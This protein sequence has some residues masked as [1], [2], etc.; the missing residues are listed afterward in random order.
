[1]KT[2]ICLLFLLPQLVWA[3]NEN[4][5]ITEKMKPLMFQVEKQLSTQ[6][7]T[8][9][10]ESLKLKDIAVRTSLRIDTSAVTK[11]YNLSPKKNKFNLPGLDESVSNSDENLKNYSP[12]IQ[13]V[14]LSIAEL[15]VKV[16]SL[17]VFTEMEKSD[18][19]KIIA[20]DL[21]TLKLNK[22]NYSFYKSKNLEPAPEPVV[23]KRVEV[24]DSK[25]DP[26]P[27][28]D[29][30][31]EENNDYSQ[32]LLA[33][34]TLVGVLL[35]VAVF[36]VGALLVRQFKNMASS[37]SSAISQIDV[38]PDHS[39]NQKSA[40]SEV[41]TQNAGGVENSVRIPQLFSQIAD[42]KH[43]FAAFMN[44][45]SGIRFY[46]I[47]EGISPSLREEFKKKLNRSQHQEYLSFLQAMA[48]GEVHPSKIAEASQQISRELS[49]YVHDADTFVGQLT[50]NKLKSLDS[51][52]LKN[53]INE[54]NEDDFMT[55][56]QVT[57]PVEMSLLLNE[58][59][60]ILERF[61]S[62][63]VREVRSD[64]LT[65]I[66]RKAEAS[67]D[68]PPDMGFSHELK[69]REF[70]PENVE[71]LLNQKLGKEKSMWEELDQ[72]GMESL[73][74]FTI[75]LS[76]KEA[77][78]FVSMIPEDIRADV[79][80]HLPD[81]KREQIK[82]QGFEVSRRSMELKHQFFQTLRA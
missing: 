35:V 63:E 44:S 57:D 81:L 75:G 9:L 30:L 58:N 78:L 65:S 76:P 46:V 67:N 80:R 68:M 56:A 15:N 38:T 69:L 41:I 20:D 10:E 53:L 37:L 36:V 43:F 12:T 59:P 31:P 74:D 47:S 77:A 5:V 29:F 45:F 28:K 32:W 7:K 52:S 18:I 34:L 51:V 61:E 22:I 66:S 4:A 40:Q 71:V 79:L 82:R 73:Y 13:D 1:M 62:L 14:Y 6:I 39:G 27:R 55:L 23:E 24:P 33:G 26:M 64:V 8:T 11:K 19:E 49:L 2:F 21:S 3:Q 50:R 42:P 48:S 25:N 17:V 16:S 72:D 60:E 54:L 70:V